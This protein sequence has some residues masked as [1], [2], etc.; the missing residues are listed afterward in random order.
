MKRHSIEEVYSAKTDDELLALSADEATLHEEA[1]Q[2][3][4]RELRRRSLDGGPVV[5]TEQRGP[6]LPLRNL[7]FLRSLRFGAILA[8][9]VC[10][11]VVATAAFE[12][13]IGNVIHPYSI[14]GLLWKWWSL[15]LTCA[16]PFGFLMWRTW[17][18]EASKWTWI[19][20]AVWFLLRF[21]FVSLSRGHESVLV[22][23]GIWYQFS[24]AD[25]ENGY[26][27]GSGC[28]NFWAF[29]VPFVRSSSFS[30]AAYFA[31]KVGPPKLKPT[32]TIE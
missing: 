21:A 28:V 27:P 19:V 30:I 6:R 7:R 20:P 10:V 4:A 29:T 2:V 9:N 18:S 24:G 3:L 12:A 15:D 26:G 25:C 1:Q 22:S 23:H 17:K 16:A 5:N 31:S 13:E 32:I 11:A 14:N 8:L